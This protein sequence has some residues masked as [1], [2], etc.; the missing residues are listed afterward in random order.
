V[1]LPDFT[2]RDISQEREAPELVGRPAE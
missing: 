2:N 1:F